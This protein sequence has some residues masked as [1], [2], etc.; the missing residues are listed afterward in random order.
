[1]LEMPA[2]DLILQK[3]KKLYCCLLILA[4]CF[5]GGRVW[6]IQSDEIILSNEHWSVTVLP[7]TFQ[8]SARPQ[9]GDE[10]LLSKGAPNLGA[11]GNIVR[12]GHQVQWI[13]E[14]K[15]IQVPIAF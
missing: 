8:M 5:V 10:I 1:M 7:V 11:V 13:L 14:T 3:S 15:G 4:V 12:T 9:G 6:A 2:L